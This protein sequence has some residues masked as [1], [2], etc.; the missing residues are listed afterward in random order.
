MASSCR[1]INRNRNIWRHM[2]S[3]W[4]IWSHQHGSNDVVRLIV[5]GTWFFFFFLIPKSLWYGIPY[6]EKFSGRSYR[7]LIYWIFRGNKFSMPE[8]LRKLRGNK[9]SRLL[10]EL[11]A[12]AGCL[13]D[14]KVFKQVYYLRLLYGRQKWS[15]MATLMKKLIFCIV[16]N[17]ICYFLILKI[18]AWIDFCGK[19]SLISRFHPKTAKLFS[20][21]TF[22]IEGI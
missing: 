14:F 6:G 13:V 22:F 12:P 10:I 2:I 18:L 1:S 21:E 17:I 8:G 20:R 11:S 16:D 7:G 15:I 9:F 3:V 4:V 5:Y 19:G